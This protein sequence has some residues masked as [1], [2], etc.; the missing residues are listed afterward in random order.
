M[1]TWILVTVRG[2]PELTGKCIDALLQN[3][4]GDWKIIIVDNGSRDET[5]DEL[6]RLFRDGKIERLVCNKVGTVPQWEKGYAI[7]QAVRLVEDEPHDLF[8]WVDNDVVVNPGWLAAAQLVLVTLADIE[9]CSLHNDNIQEKRH[10]TIRTERVGPYTVRRKLTA[11]G[12]A[13][14]MRSGFFAKYGLPPIGMGINRE[15][16]EDWFYSDKLQHDGRPRFGIV[17]GFAEHLGYQCSIKRK[18]IAEV[19]NHSVGVDA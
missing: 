10:K 8:A 13:W 6:Y 7:R 18:A 2:R 4:P 12:A 3:T 15:G 16:T 14:V 11:N 5:L 1:T 19:K 9:V 17:E